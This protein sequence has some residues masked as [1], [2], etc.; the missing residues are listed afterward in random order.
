M[1]MKMTT[2]RHWERP[3]VGRREG[4]MDDKLPVGYYA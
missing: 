4:N 2:S 1:E 3:D